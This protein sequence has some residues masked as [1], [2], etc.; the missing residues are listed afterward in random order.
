MTAPFA[1]VVD[2]LDRSLGRLLDWAAWLALPVSTLLFLQWPLRDIVKAYSRDANDMAQWI[3]AL[4]VGLALTAATRAGGHLSADFLAQRYS[5]AARARI[6][7]CGHLIATIP[8]SLFVLVAGAP[9]TWQS[10]RQLEGFPDTYNPGYFIVKLSAW[11]LAATM[12]AQGMI[13]VARMFRVR[14]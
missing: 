4:Y 12:F 3:F 1:R 5:A 6:A 10:L 11:L 7:A 9:A 13:D 8:W 14:E 2:A